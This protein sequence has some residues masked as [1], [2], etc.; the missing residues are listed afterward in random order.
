VA[1]SALVEEALGATAAA[2]ADI[3][4]WNLPD[5]VRVATA[6]GRSDLA[7]RLLEGVHDS[8]A[9]YRLAVGSARAEIAESTGDLA[10]AETLHRIAADAWGEYGH[11][12]ERSLSLLGLGRSLVGLGRPGAAEAPLREAREALAKLAAEP[13]VADADAWL[14]RVGSS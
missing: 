13:H 12:M 8:L 3:R 11:V 6:A 10:S 1:A 2:G 9:R 5:L 7:E 14:D 4:A